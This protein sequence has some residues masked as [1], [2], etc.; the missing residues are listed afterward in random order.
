[1]NKENIKI[2]ALFFLAALL[3]VIVV[4]CK[5]PKVASDYFTPEVL[6]TH[7][8]G[9]QFVGSE[10]CKECHSAI[11]ESHLKTA[12]FN[13]SAPANAERIKGSFKEDANTVNLDDVRLVMEENNR[14]F[15]EHT[16]P[17]WG[18]GKKSVQ[19]M[20]IVIG[21]GVKG[22]SYLTWDLDRLYQ[23]QVSYYT[24]T[25]S[26]I[27]SPNF[28]S[29]S[30]E[31]PITD[32]CLKCHATFANNR[33]PSGNGN[34]YIKENTIYGIDCERCHRPAAKHVIYHR[35]NP[36]ATTA[37][38][39]IPIDTLSRQL[40]LDACVQCH[41]GL[42]SQQLKGSPFSFVTGD[43]LD[44]YSKNY[45]SGRPDTELDVHGNQY[46]LLTSSACFE[47]SPKM[48]CTTCHSPHE[49]QRG[50]T[51]YFNQKCISCHSS[52]TIEC[53]VDQLES[54]SM[55]N[56]CIACHMPVSPSKTMKVK[57]ATDSVEIPVYIRSHLIATY[58][59]PSKP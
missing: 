21:S 8:N 14:A 13:T 51:T 57:L 40:R 52:N 55:G 44:T 5:N 53:S 10:T 39:M 48:D 42:R 31:R 58:P 6:A 24:P 47:A 33:E 29:R 28:P 41:S 36:G 59:I 50:N 18:G 19:K 49:N 35:K 45:Y 20:D 30:T 1:M 56:N 3:A 46:G 37:K 15:Y 17:K 9:E 38:F 54:G 32:A 34:Q 23:L 16:I 7:F 4:R 12:H 25:D 11:Y 26:W 27:N 43:R 2:G 22:Q